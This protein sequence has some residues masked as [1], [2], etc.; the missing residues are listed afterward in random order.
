MLV[1]GN[2]VKGIN[3]KLSAC[4]KPIYGD[5]IVGFIA[6]DGAVKIHRTN[7]G[8]IRHLLSKYPYRMIKSQWS[9]KIGAQFVANIRV[10]GRDE[11]GIVSNITS[12]INKTDTA[13]L[14]NIVIDSNGGMF[15]GNLVIGVDSLDNLDV[16]IK[17]IGTLKG[18]IQVSRV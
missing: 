14:R 4:C 1:I 17:K 16:L 6:S 13:T 12:M 8:N 15:E 11:I 7:C 10:V 9:E 3:Y 18:V 5:K 2:D